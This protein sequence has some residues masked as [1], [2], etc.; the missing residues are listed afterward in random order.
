MN[1]SDALLMQYRSPVGAGPSLAHRG[2][3]RHA[4]AQG[5]VEL[6]ACGVAGTGARRDGDRAFVRT[7][8]NYTAALRANK[9]KAL[10]AQL[11][12]PITR[13]AG[14]GGACSFVGR[15]NYPLPQ[16]VGSHPD[17]C[18]HTE[19]TQSH[20]LTNRLRGARREKNHEPGQ[21]L[22]GQNR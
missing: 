21:H 20:T 5:F 15:Q 1:R 22:E 4:R 7:T 11:A 17:P 6:Q 16:Q 10:S 2:D 9:P 13:S 8:C 12:Q 14:Q 19:C 3:L 18:C